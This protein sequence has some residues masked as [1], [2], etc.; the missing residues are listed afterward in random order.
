MCEKVC[1]ELDVVNSRFCV[2][3]RPAGIHSLTC[4]W[5]FLFQ[6]CELSATSY[7]CVFL[8]LFSNNATNCRLIERS[9]TT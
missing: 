2:L 9:S 7:V 1:V 5:P 8:Q 3:A 4:A 6:R